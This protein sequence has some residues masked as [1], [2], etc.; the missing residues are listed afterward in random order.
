MKHQ[1]IIGIDPAYRQNGFGLCVRDLETKTLYFY[2]IKDFLTFQTSFANF[3]K[4]DVATLVVVENS[5]LQ[6]ANFKNTAKNAKVGFAMGLSVG[7]NQAISEL[8]CQW[9]KTL[10]LPYLE[11][12]EVSPQV[13]GAKLQH[14]DFL[15]IIL[16]EGIKEVFGYKGLAKEQDSRDAGKLCLNY[17]ALY[18]HNKI[19]F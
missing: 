5:N 10:D 19:I 13:K 2:P 17:R 14:L 4:K 12:L 11:V 3:L 18:N 9:L 8:V 16:A 1:I 15:A 7:K 6:N